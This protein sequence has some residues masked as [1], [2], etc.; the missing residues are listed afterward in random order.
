[1]R[2]NTL[3]LPFLAVFLIACSVTVFCQQKK[4]SKKIK[5]Y[6]AIVDVTTQRRNIVGV[7]Q[8]AGDSAIYVLTK[9]GMD[10]IESSVIKQIV[11]KRK[12]NVGRGA[13]A[14]SL[15]GIG[16]GAII[17]FASGDDECDSPG[18]C[19]E[20]TAE[21]KAFVNGFV[22]SGVG[23]LIGWGVGSIGKEHIKIGE[24]QF[25]FSKNV[26]LLRKYSMHES[27]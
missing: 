4:Q 13:L 16:V 8:E 21:E 10:R 23:A 22:L 15:I 20:V 7:L 14:G 6:N 1:M 25:V 18:F 3:S 9:N 5:V 12:G 11:I 26:A 2:P 24:N 17:G 19:F 27:L